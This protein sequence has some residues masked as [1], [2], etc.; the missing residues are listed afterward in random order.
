MAELIASSCPTYSTPK[1][2]PQKVLRHKCQNTF[3]L[4]FTFPIC[5]YSPS[6]DAELSHFISPLPFTIKKDFEDLHFTLIE[7]HLYCILYKQVLLF[8]ATLALSDSA[9]FKNAC[10]NIICIIKQ[11]SNSKGKTS[12]QLETH[13]D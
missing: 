10:R 4:T 3:T 8:K 13:L 1:K 12:Y 2:L 5:V 11:I 7:Y 6:V 9:E